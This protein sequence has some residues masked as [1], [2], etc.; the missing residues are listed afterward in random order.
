MKILSLLSVMLLSN[1]VPINQNINYV[2]WYGQ[3]LD[4]NVYL[5]RS[6][7]NI[8]QDN[9]YFIIEPTYFVKLTESANSQFYKAEYLDITGFI[10]K[11]QV[12]VVKNKPTTPYLENINFRVFSSSS[13]Q[14]RTV[15]SSS[16]GSKTQVAYIPLFSKDPIYYGKIYGESAIEGRTNVWYYCKFSYDKDYYGYIYSD[17][18]DQMKSFT[19]NSGTYEYVDYPDFSLKIEPTPSAIIEKS[20]NKYKYL[21][22]LISIP[23]AIFLI[24]II[25]GS[26]ILKSNKKERAKE[27]KVF[28]D[29]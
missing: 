18:C 26:I 11:S 28:L 19:K 21:I 5:Y 14:M 2:E 6:P 22:V 16:G 23:V 15:P 29:P 9:V 8:I 24:M 1:I 13:Q 12:Q 7:N 20:S 3:I 10:K 17:G 25:R 4:Q 27:V